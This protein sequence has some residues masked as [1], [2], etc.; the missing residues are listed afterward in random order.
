MWGSV[1]GRIVT[2]TLSLCVALLAAEAQPAGKM[3]RIGVIMP[4][5]P[6]GASGDELDGFRQGLRALGYVE[7]QTIALEVRWGAGQRERYPALAADLVQWPIDVIVTAGGAAAR[8]ARH[9][10]DRNF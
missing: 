8:A 2:L 6:P 5:V 4:G 1:I 7:G 3:P 10:G 9:A